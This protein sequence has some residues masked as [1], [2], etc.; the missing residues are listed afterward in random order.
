MINRRS[1]LTTTG[2]GA[3]ALLVL[4]TRSRAETLTA[5]AIFRDPDQP[6]LGN[7]DGDITIAEFFD[8]QCPFCKKDH[9]IVESFVKRDG[10]IRLVMKD[11]PIFGPPSLYASQLVLGASTFG[12]YRKGLEALMD[13]PGRL[14]DDEIDKLLTD[15][16]VDLAKA[17][18]AYNAEKTRWDGL[19]ARTSG[20][21]T[22]LGLRGTPA[23]VIGHVIYS[24]LMDDDALTKA[25]AKARA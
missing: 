15:A 7:P 4:P 23:F 3:G 22:A 10:K 25:V 18:A 21:A 6:V 8:Y 24:G 9:P 16:G 14:T 11:W 1:F 17:K 19:L 20:Q 12:G 2:L 5:D 13:T